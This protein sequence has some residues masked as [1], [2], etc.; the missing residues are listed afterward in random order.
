[1]SNFDSGE[2]PKSLPM[3]Y[4]DSVKYWREV[5]LDTVHDKCDLNNQFVWYNVNIRLGNKTVYNDRLMKCGLW[6]VSDL[7]RNGRLILYNE[8]MNRGALVTDFF[9]W[10]CLI[11]GIPQDW[12]QMLLD[13]Q[14]VPDTHDLGIIAFGNVNTNIYDFTEKS[15]K[16]WYKQQALTM[17]GEKDCKSK[18]KFC[19]LFDIHFFNEEMWNMI[20]EIPFTYLV[21]NKLVELQYK[22]L[23]RSVATNKLLYKMG[24]VQS[25]TCDF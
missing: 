18:A 19:T 4:L 5:K 9:K 6:Y 21:D 14:I 22:I 8:W 24:K 3:Y 7:Y 1:M 25:P 2:L 15:L 20:Y 23:H 11:D 17:L 16:Q 12:K 10:R 13:M